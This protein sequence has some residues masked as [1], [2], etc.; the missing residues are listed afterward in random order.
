MAMP[1]PPPWAEFCEIVLSVTV[2][3][4][5]SPSVRMAPPKPAPPAAHEG[6]VPLD[7]A[8]GD[9]QVTLVADGA[10]GPRGAAVEQGHVADLRRDPGGNLEDAVDAAAVDAGAAGAVADQH[11]VAGDVQVTRAARALVAGPR[12][13]VGAGVEQDDVLARPRVGGQHGFPQGAV[14]VTGAV[15]RIGRLGGG[16]DRRSRGLPDPGERHQRRQGDGDAEGL[17]HLGFHFVSF[18]RL[19]RSSS[20]DG[21]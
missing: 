3:T 20:N 2:R 9:R 13:H 16:E 8:A 17:F 19:R 18:N 10:A 6:R 11:Q 1:P 5:P 15:R 7:H 21:S 4:D 12:Q 14:G